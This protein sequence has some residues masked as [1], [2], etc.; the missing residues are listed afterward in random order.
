M[1]LF[2]FMSAGGRAGARQDGGGM[3]SRGRPRGA[4]AAQVLPGR[5]R[6]HAAAAAGAEP[7]DARPPAGDLRAPDRCAGRALVRAAADFPE[8]FI[9]SGVVPK[10]RGITRDKKALPLECFFHFSFVILFVVSFCLLRCAL[11]KEK[12]F[13]LLCSLKI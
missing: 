1:R 8:L 7:E 5:P 10:L 13:F 2:H 12:K 6:E 11:N 3:R 4:R 9:H